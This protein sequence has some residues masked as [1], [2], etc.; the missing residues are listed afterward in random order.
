MLRV[1][2]YYYFFALEE[3]KLHV[4]FILLS[5]DLLVVLIGRHVGLS[6]ANVVFD[7][8]GFVSMKWN[9]G[10]SLVLLKVVLNGHY[11]LLSTVLCVNAN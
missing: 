1:H 11:A 7:Y 3:V 4:I 9:R 10:W 6:Q 5:S 2:L 8:V